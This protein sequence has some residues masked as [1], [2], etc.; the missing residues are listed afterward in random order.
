M[1]RGQYS[2]ISL[3]ELIDK[4]MGEVMEEHSEVTDVRDFGLLVTE[5]LVTSPNLSWVQGNIWS[6]IDDTVQH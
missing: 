5:A 4:A 3:A 2:I 1:T 6:D